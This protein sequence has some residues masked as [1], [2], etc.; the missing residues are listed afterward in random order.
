MASILK[1]YSTKG[2][3]LKLK[4]IVCIHGNSFWSKRGENVNH[5]PKIMRIQQIPPQIDSRKTMHIYFDCKY[6]YKQLSQYYPTTRSP[7]Q[8][9]T[10]P[11]YRQFYIFSSYA[12]MCQIFSVHIFFY[13]EN[14]SRFFFLPL[15]RVIK[16]VKARCVKQKSDSRGPASVLIQLILDQKKVQPAAPTRSLS[17]A[18]YSGGRGRGGSGWW[19]A[20]LGGGGVRGVHY[21]SSPPPIPLFK[22]AKT[23]L[24]G[25]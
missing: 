6:Y 5:L 9:H 21:L 10:M 1:S 2:M 3:E 23:L 11:N 16:K 14:F 15:Y 4:T 8:Y 17:Q 22:S 25:T 20:G 7:L 19:M 18:S 24:F 13:V 12:P